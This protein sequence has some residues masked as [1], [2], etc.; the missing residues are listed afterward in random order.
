M[1]FV[2]L[3]DPILKNLPPNLHL[4]DFAGTDGVYMMPIP[5]P[6][7]DGWLTSSMV[8]LLDDSGRGLRFEINSIEDVLPNLKKAIEVFD[9]QAGKPNYNEPTMR[10]PLAKTGD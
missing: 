2:N 7:G 8:I 6:A 3:I 4:Y 5:D 10:Y 9:S 1:S